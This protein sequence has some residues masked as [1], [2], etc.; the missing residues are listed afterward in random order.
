MLGAIFLREPVNGISPAS[1]SA[2]GAFIGLNLVLFFSTGYVEATTLIADGED[3]SVILSERKEAADADAGVSGD[4]G[5]RRRARWNATT[6]V[7]EGT[8]LRVKAVGRSVA[9]PKLAGYLILSATE[10]PLSKHIL[11]QLVALVRAPEGFDDSVT[12]RCRPGVSVG[13]RL[14][15]KPV[16]KGMKQTITSMVLDFGCNRLVIGDARGDPNAEASYFDPSRAAFVELVKLAFPDD[17]ELE[18]LRH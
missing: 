2:W 8:V 14:R 6:N 5:A 12:K 10:R 3:A 16:A 15:R 13:F 9:G 18:A 4:W 11:D 17:R 1:F 7:V